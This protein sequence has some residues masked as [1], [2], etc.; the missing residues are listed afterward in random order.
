MVNEETMHAVASMRV[1]RAGTTGN[2]VYASVSAEGYH[3]ADGMTAVMWDPQKTYTQGANDNN[4]LNLNVDLAVSGATVTTEYGGGDPLAGWAISVMYG[5]STLSGDDVPA[6]L[7]DDGMAGFKMSVA[8][9]PAMFT[10][11][12]DTIQDNKL[13]GGEKF[14]ATDATYMHTGL[15]LAGMADAGTMEVTYTTQSLK[16]YVHHEMDQVMGYT[17]NVLGG[18]ERM[19]GMVDLS[20]RYIDGNGRSRA[21]TSKEWNAGA[22]TK[23]DDD[24]PGVTTFTG[25]PADADIIVQA[26]EAADSLNI[27][28]LDPD[29]LA[30]YTDLEENGVM[31]GAFG[32]MGGFSH[33]VELCPLM[34]TDPT[35]QDHG[36]CGSFGFVDTHQVNGLVW[37]HGVSMDTGDAVYDVAAVLIGLR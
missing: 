23:T 25:L 21:F 31:G 5:D 4:I 7:G 3:V 34:R 28:L 10:F 32:A 37:K 16:V 1:A 6:M 24:E 29:E 15:T 27:M 19:S 30:A 22:N 2:M 9:V 36:E 18:D 17:G 12:V 33:T 26:D 35:A 8:S 20:V 14:E 13:D 11:S